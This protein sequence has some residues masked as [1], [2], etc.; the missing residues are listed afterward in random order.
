MPIYYIEASETVFYRMYV[1]TN[2]EKDDA[3]NIVFEM[4]NS[5]I[6]ITDFAEDGEGFQIDVLGSLGSAE[7]LNEHETVL[8]EQKDGENNIVRTLKMKTVRETLLNNKK[9][10]D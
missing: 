1:Y 9:E 7:Y 4:E 3:K 5:G 10:K 6:D 2:G 8:V